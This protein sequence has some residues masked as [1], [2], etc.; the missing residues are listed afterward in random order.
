MIFQV[1]P[2]DRFPAKIIV[3]I[4]MVEINLDGGNYT[5]LWPSD[6]WHGCG[7]NKIASAE[8]IDKDKPSRLKIE[9]I[10]ILKDYNFKIMKRN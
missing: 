5:P 1:N 9:K 10:E 7:R 2:T 4:K 3:L 6:R 8:T